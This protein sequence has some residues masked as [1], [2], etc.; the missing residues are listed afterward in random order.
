MPQRPH[1]PVLKPA[2]R[3]TGLAATTAA[4]ASS[5]QERLRQEL[6]AMILRNEEARKKRPK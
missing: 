2:T 4:V 1:I 3:G 5:E 6:R